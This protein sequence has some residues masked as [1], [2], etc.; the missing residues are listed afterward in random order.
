MKLKE[1]RKNIQI[2]ESIYNCKLFQYIDRYNV[3]FS[4]N[5]KGKKFKITLE[6]LKRRIKKQYKDFFIAEI[7]D[8]IEE[9]AENCNFTWLDQ[10]YKSAK[11]L[12]N[13]LNKETGIIHS[14]T[15]DVIK[16]L[17][18]IPVFKNKEYYEYKILNKLKSLNMIAL[19]KE[20]YHDK[21][22]ISIKCL[23]C[24][25]V[26][27]TKCAFIRKMT[28]CTNCENKAFDN[29][30]INKTK[31]IRNPFLDY[32]LYFVKFEIVKS[33]EIVYK[34]GL[35]KSK[36]IKYR[37]C[38]RDYKNYEILHSLNLPLYK[39]FYIEQTIMQNFKNF[40]YNG[41][42]KFS[43]YTEC[44]NID[45]DFTKVINNIVTLFE[46]IQNSK[47]CELLGSP[48]EGNQQPS[49]IEI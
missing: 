25:N 37:F 4:N 31:V 33:G 27:S 24:N 41:K 34:I 35:F 8:K 3:I 10:E 12:L 26:K 30:F 21:Q 20:I 2:F 36:D 32:Y 17:N 42:E 6:T 43:G 15:W 11:S 44:F 45:V 49:I 46:E 39:A 7:V 28:H 47:L 23:K 38:Y 48:E 18:S 16:R 5:R 19:S 40:K 14:S 13:F 29:N 22:I 1:T 9:I